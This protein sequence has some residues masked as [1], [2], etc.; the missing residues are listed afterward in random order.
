MSDNLYTAFD[1]L[2]GYFYVS[3]TL[4]ENGSTIYYN[5]EED[6]YGEYISEFSATPLDGNSSKN[7]VY[8]KRHRS[9]K[10]A[11]AL[12]FIYLFIYGFKQQR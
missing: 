3:D 12:V 1:D 11:Y 8:V 5:M 2:V 4:Q 10:G 7:A 9:D 6:K